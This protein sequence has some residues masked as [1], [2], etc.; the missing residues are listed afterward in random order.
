MKLKAPNDNVHLQLVLDSILRNSTNNLDLFFYKGYNLYKEN[1]GNDNP[2]RF[3]LK[4]KCILEEWEGFIDTNYK[5]RIEQLLL[6][7]EKS[8]DSSVIADC[9]YE[10]ANISKDDFPFNLFHV[11]RDPRYGSIKYSL[12]STIKDSIEEC[13]LM[14]IND[15]QSEKNRKY[16]VKID[17]T[18]AFGCS[19][20]NHSN[21]RVI[22]DNLSYDDA[23]RLQ[24]LISTLTTTKNAAKNKEQ[25][26]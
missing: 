19:H 4:C 16:V 1:G 13:K 14:L 21:H 22:I 17:D 24:E 7:R 10:I 11:A 12:I 3:F 23:L 18:T 8:K 5:K 6:I 20:H 25:K 15:E 2:T 26:K 9:N